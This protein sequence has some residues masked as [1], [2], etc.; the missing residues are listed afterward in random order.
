MRSIL[1]WFMLLAACSQGQ[2]PAPSIATGTFA[3]E[4]RDRLCIAGEPGNYRG[5][6][7]VYADGDVNCSAGGKIDAANGA[8]A[9]VPRG[10][11][12]CRIPLAIDGNAVRIGDVPAACSYYCGPGAAMAG[13]TFNR[14]DAG[15]QVADLAGDPLC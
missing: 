9:L 15:G 12:D 1:P 6:L 13:K 14:S 7:I 3:G 2:E 5:G 11:G 4:G 10:E 8:I